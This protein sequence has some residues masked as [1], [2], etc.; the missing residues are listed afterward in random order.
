MKHFVLTASSADKWFNCP[1]SINAEEGIEEEYTEFLSEEALAH[2]LAEVSLNSGCP[3]S[4][5][6]ELNDQEIT[7]DMA[8]YV[9]DYIYYVLSH[10]SY[11]DKLTVE[12]E[13][14]FDEYAQ[15]GVGTLDASVMNYVEGTCHIF[16]LEYGTDIPIYA[17]NNTQLMLYALGML[18]SADYAWRIERFV[19]HV[20]QPRLQKISSF[21]ISVGKIKE[22]GEVVKAKEEILRP[23]RT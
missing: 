7:P 3:V 15:G 14:C 18:Q 12:S 13:V 9:Q 4:T 20:H 2:L 16:D 1:G 19:M 11:N 17:E 23:R 22:F 21:E 5:Y 8:D 6:D 10:I